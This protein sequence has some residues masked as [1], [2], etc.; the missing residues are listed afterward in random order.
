MRRTTGFATNAP[1]A[2]CENTRGLLL[3]Q[4]QNT[5]ASASRTL[6]DEWQI[7]TGPRAHVGLPAD[8]RG[9]WSMFRKDIQATAKRL[10]VPNS[11]VIFE[12]K[13]RDVIQRFAVDKTMPN[14]MSQKEV[15]NALGTDLTGWKKVL[16]AVL[17]AA[18]GNLPWGG[19]DA[20]RYGERRTTPWTN[21]ASS[22]VPWVVSGGD[23]LFSEDVYLFGP[24]IFEIALR[25][26]WA[27]VA[28]VRKPTCARRTQAFKKHVCKV[29][30]GLKA[31][32]E[33]A[34][35]VVTVVP[36]MVEKLEVV[37]RPIP[38][39]AIVPE[40]QEAWP[41]GLPR[42]F[43]GMTS[44]YGAYLFDQVKRISPIKTSDELDDVCQEIWLKLMNA[45]VLEKF[46]STALSK[47]P[48]T[49]TYPQ[50]LRFLGVTHQDFQ[51]AVLAAP[52]ALKPVQGVEMDE[53][54]LYSTAQLQTLDISGLLPEVRDLDRCRPEATERGFK[55]YLTRAVKNHFKNILRY[56]GRKHKERGLD[57]STL[58][59]ADSSGVYTKAAVLEESGSWED[60]V[61]DLSEMPM[62]AMCDLVSEIRRHGLDV[63]S[64]LGMAVLDQVIANT[65]KGMTLR[66]ALE[67]VTKTK[68][69]VRA[70]H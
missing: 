4:V 23:D 8:Y 40:K 1:K 63:T 19:I 44:Q 18:G 14:D 68:Q 22:L 3:T 31:T 15:C 27:Q 6:C 50:A 54:S 49:M 16:K 37:E 5:S 35:P 43:E 56:R 67:S 65:K 34:K 7:A 38:Q 12:L 55:T 13:K 2:N 11:A 45:K 21:Q 39:P 70:R 17:K 62:E 42:T 20:P 41:R 25:M 59:A 61:A 51:A 69:Q 58:L 32:K 29:L 60:S 24:S 66:E 26:D 9:L 36:Q 30:A 33:V 47:L 46:A 53:A 48:S 57:G 52:F 28:L 10:G 64:E